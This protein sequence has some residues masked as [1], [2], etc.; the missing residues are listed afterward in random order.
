MCFALPTVEMFQYFNLWATLQW[1]LQLLY[2][3]GG[4]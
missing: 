2:F 4:N 3:Y 1:E